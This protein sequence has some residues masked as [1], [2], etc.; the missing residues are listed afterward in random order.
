MSSTKTAARRR[1]H[2]AR[3]SGPRL[4]PIARI[5]RA[6]AMAPRLVR[7]EVRAASHAAT[8]QRF[9]LTLRDS[10]LVA[11]QPVTAE[12]AVLRDTDD[13]LA[14]AE[15]Q[16]WWLDPPATSRERADP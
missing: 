11:V 12:G 5:E 7:L 6:L 13:M 2:R 3:R 8:G 16:D 10:R 4:E 1:A 14:W 9:T 15:R